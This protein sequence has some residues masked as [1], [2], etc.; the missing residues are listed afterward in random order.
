MKR[1]DSLNNNM[2][3]PERRTHIMFY[4]LVGNELSETVSR[5][6]SNIVVFQNIRKGEGETV[7]IQAKGNHTVL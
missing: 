7:I 4:Y 1:S 3:L 6:N 2:F 5:F